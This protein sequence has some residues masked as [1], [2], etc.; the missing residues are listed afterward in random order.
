MGLFLFFSGFAD[1]WLEPHLYLLAGLSMLLARR[2]LDEPVAAPVPEP[3]ED[4]SMRGAPA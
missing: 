3:D 1:I 4:L 2:D